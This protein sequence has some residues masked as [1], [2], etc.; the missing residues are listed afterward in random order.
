MPAKLSVLPRYGVM[1][2]S[3]FGHVKATEGVTAFEDYLAHPDFAPGQKHL[4]DFSQATGFE[5]DYTNLMALQ[6]RLIEAVM[7]N[8][9]VLFVYCAPTQLAEDM[10]H[11]SVTAWSNVKKVVIR[12]LK[13]EAEAM[14]V[15]GLSGMT[16]T[17]LCATTA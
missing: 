16:F 15:I 6:A 8:Q 7:P 11:L 17:E 12:V 2:V 1:Y 9:Q 13:T 3:F 4:I 5:G 14:D 10:A